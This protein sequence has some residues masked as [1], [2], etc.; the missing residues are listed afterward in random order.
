MRWPMLMVDA[1]E[2]VDPVAVAQLRASELG[3]MS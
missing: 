1:M 2:Q 3:L